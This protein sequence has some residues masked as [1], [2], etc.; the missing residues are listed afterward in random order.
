MRVVHVT[1]AAIAT[2]AMLG[3]MGIVAAYAEP[4][5]VAPVA[6]GTGGFVVFGTVL[7]IVVHDISNRT[8]AVVASEIDDGV[9]VID[10]TD[11][12]D[13]LPTAAITD[14][15]GGFTKLNGA[16]SIAIHDVSNR[17]YGVVAGYEG[18]QVIDITDPADPLPA[19]W[20]HGGPIVALHD[21]SGE[22]HLLVNGGYSTGDVS[23]FN[24]AHLGSTGCFYD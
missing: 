7:N 8:Y 3:C 15:A 23:I 20:L 17:T 12:A 11:P 21:I 10:I 2:A 5:P 13:P 9:Q 1:C 19:A 6:D 16:T 18:V 14:D 4:I 24:I 22:A